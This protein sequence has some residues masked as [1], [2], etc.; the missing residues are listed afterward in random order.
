MIARPMPKA[1]KKSSKSPKLGALPEWD[2]DDLYPGLD[3]PELKWDLEQRR[4][5]L[6]CV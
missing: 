6:L 2:L 1:A 3:S 5:P 4:N